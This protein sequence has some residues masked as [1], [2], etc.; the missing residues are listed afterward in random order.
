MNWRNLANNSSKQVVKGKNFIFA[1]FNHC[2]NDQITVTAG[3][4]AFVSLLSIVPLISVTFSILKAFPVFESFKQS[5]EGFIFS[6][7]VPTSG[8]QIQQYING[9]VDNASQMTA[10]GI[11]VL[12]VVA[13]SLISSIDKTLNRIWGSH[14]RRKKVFSFAVYWMVLTLGPIFVGAS[15][16]VTSYVVSIAD[17]YTPGVSDFFIKLLPFCLSTLAFV[18]LFM[19]VP[20]T[21]VKFK[22]AISGAVIAAVL[23]EVSKRVFALYITSFDSYQVIYGALASI[24]I[25]FLWVYVSWVVVLLGAEFTVFIDPYIEP[26]TKPLGDNLSDSLSDNLDENKLLSKNITE[27]ISQ[28]TDNTLSAERE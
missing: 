7:F 5:L 18:L 1:F 27:R 6:N 15:L 28:D 2:R 9:F 14:E 10:V 8:E 17:S 26:S 25:L 19:I 22:A 11:V 3:Y 16:G 24:P 20:N 4:L 23:F 12:I 21:E 13:L